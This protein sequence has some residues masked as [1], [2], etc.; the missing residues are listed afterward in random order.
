MNVLPA[1]VPSSTIVL[2]SIAASNSSSWYG[3]A[4]ISPV[5][6]AGELDDRSNST[7][8]IVN[9]WVWLLVQADYIARTVTSRNLERAKI[10]LGEAIFDESSMTSYLCHVTSVRARS[11]YSLVMDSKLQE[12]RIFEVSAVNRNST[13]NCSDYSFSDSSKCLLHTKLCHKGRSIL[14]IRKGKPYNRHS[15]DH[16]MSATTCNIFKST[17]QPE[18]QPI[19][20]IFLKVYSSPLPKWTQLS[21]RR[22][23]NWGILLIIH[24]QFVTRW[25]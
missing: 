18:A 7:A 24:Y 5:T 22:L 25:L 23:Q 9:F 15:S 19:S 13:E 10:I 21:H 4:S 11:V 12:H 8:S 1:P 3:R 14:F 16:M 20:V 17:V 2:S 6:A